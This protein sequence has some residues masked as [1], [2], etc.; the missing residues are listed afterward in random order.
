VVDGLLGCLGQQGSIFKKETT[1]GCALSKGLNIGA[2]TNDLIQ[3]PTTSQRV[4]RVSQGR[5]IP[6][7]ACF[8]L[9]AFAKVYWSSNYLMMMLGH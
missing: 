4:G 8:C 6:R 7:S 3:I 2:D 9:T 5:L 1:H